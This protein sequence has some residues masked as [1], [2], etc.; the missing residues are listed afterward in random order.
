MSVVACS[1]NGK[2]WIR[3]AIKLLAIALLPGDNFTT[4]MALRPMLDAFVSPRYAL[5]RALAS[6]FA[7]HVFPRPLCQAAVL[8]AG[9]VGVISSIDVRMSIGFLPALVSRTEP[10][11]QNHWRRCDEVS[12]DNHSD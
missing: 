2:S 10:Q 1:T 11:P 8:L 9:F 3:H 5:D 7:A 4:L 12:L 6:D